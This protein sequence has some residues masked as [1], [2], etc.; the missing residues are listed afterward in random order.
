M[1]RL[2]TF[3]I[4]DRHEHV[5]GD[6][7]NYVIT[8]CVPRVRRLFVFF[9]IAKGSYCFAL[10]IVLSS[11]SVPGWVGHFLIPSFA[12]SSTASARARYSA[13]HT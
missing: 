8:F 13:M 7:R 2:S 5:F 12:K 10:T 6:L 11:V 3:R 4:A 9:H 1:R